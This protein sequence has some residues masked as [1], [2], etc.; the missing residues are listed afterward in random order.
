MLNESLCTFHFVNVLYNFILCISYLS[1]LFLICTVT[2]HDYWTLPDQ[3]QQS[4]L[5]LQVMFPYTRGYLEWMYRRMFSS[6]LKTCTL[7]DILW[8]HPL[9]A[10]TRIWKRATKNTRNVKED[11]RKLLLGGHAYSW[12]INTHYEMLLLENTRSWRGKNHQ[13]RGKRRRRAGSWRSGFYHDLCC[14]TC[15][16]IEVI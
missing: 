16:L 7:S 8:R 15:V 2:T 11:R 13:W 10:P 5:V 6:Q 3:V 9:E 1:F 14:S 12:G 4:A